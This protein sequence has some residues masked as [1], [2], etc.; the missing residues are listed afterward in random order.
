MQISKETQ[1]S[2]RRMAELQAVI[3]RDGDHTEDY[4]YKKYRELVGPVVQEVLPVVELLVKAGIFEIHVGHDPSEYLGDTV[5][6]YWNVK[7]LYENE[8]IVICAGDP[9]QW[10]YLKQPLTATEGPVQ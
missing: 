3:D 6:T 10:N 1:T 2:L 5:P 4:V 9:C 7:A 8:G